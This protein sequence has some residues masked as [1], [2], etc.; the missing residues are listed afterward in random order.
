MSPIASAET[1]LRIDLAVNA[2][3][4]LV[5]RM[6]RPPRQNAQGLDARVQGLQDGLSDGGPGAHDFSGKA[7]AIKASLRSISSIR[8]CTQAAEVRGSAGVF[9]Q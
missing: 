9:R 4:P 8:C 3:L 6:R 2:A 7:W 1:A 5:H